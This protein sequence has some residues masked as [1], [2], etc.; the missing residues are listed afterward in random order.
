MRR[1]FRFGGRL[2]IGACTVVILG[3]MLVLQREPL[4]ARGAPVSID[5]VRRARMLL[6]RHD[7]R[8]ARAG[9]LRTIALSPAD[10]TLLAQYGASRW[11][12]VSAR[13]ALQAGEATV[14]ASLAMSVTPLATWLNLDADLQDAD[15]LPAIRRLRIGH[16]PV[17][18]FASQRL[19]DVLL[20]RLGAAAPFAVARESV[21]RTEFLADSLR[22][23]YAWGDDAA[24]RVRDLLIS[25]D[26]LAR[27]EAYN[28]RLAAYIST[29]KS[30]TPIPLPQLLTP[31][32]ALAEQRAV[33]GDAA[34]ENRAA[35]ATLA[36]YVTH[37]S[38]GA[39]MRQ[40]KAWPQAKRRSV[41]LLGREDLAKHFVVSAIVAAEADR[42]LADAVGLTKEVE[43]SRGGS[44][45]SFV[46]LA[47][48]KAG[49]RFGTLAVAS[50]DA[51]QRAAAAGLSVA[52]IMPDVSGL[53]ESLSEAQLNERFGGVGAAPYAAM[54]AS[55]DARVA[56]LPLLR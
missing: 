42:M 46:D 49:T 14:Q 12:T 26:D 7:P 30:S 20:S 41:T 17:P 53:P 51:L 28:A 23:R 19:I 44:G 13:V 8:T 38:L 43:D 24:G 10:A 54:L 35:L 32:F 45:F 34:A 1:V 40:T 25:P 5:D 21:R 15:G 27:L 18:A 33:D 48:D 9:A 4:V 31:V 56:A 50:P 2:I 11:R 29:T 22:V 47:A 3:A 6:V 36:L 16:L 52:E 39:W 37:R 55:V